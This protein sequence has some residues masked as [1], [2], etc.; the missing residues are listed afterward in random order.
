MALTH[1]RLLELVEYDAATGIFTKKLRSGHAPASSKTNG[2]GY[3]RLCIDY[4]SY[5]QHRLAWFYMHEVWP[6]GMVDH[7]NGNTTDNRISNLRC[8]DQT[9]N[10]LNRHRP[11][12]QNR[13]RLIG[14]H[15]LANGRF[16][17]DIRIGG[18]QKRLGTYPTAELAHAAYMQ[19]KERLMTQIQGGC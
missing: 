1:E 4:R 6:N 11:H 5:Q 8:A 14:A 15:L 3:L 16:G 17:A 19:A 18:R 7:I 13:S 10:Q 2:S 9:L 12:P